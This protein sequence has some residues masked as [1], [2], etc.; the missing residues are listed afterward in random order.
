MN[1]YELK[2]RWGDKLTFWGCLGSQS[3][4]PF[5]TPAEIRSEVGRLCREMGKGGGFILS[6]A[7]SLQPETPTENAVAVVE[8]FTEQT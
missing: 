4:I 7:K 8:A 1:P 6:P 2:K 3:I 5:G